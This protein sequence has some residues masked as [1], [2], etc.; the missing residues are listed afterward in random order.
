[1]S[2]NRFA[3]HVLVFP[4]DDANRQIAVG[5]RLDI[6]W[7]RR[8]AILPVAGGWNEVLDRFVTDHIPEME[9]NENRLMILLIDFDGQE[10]R[11][12][13]ASARI[14]AHLA[15]R[16]FILGV[17]TNPEHLRQTMHESFETIGTLL[18]QDCRDGTATTWNRDLLRH[19]ER[20][21]DRLR[22]LVHPI[23]Y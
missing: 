14:P 18:S 19:N 10:D 6:K 16:V 1:V 5:F 11:F 20:E 2:V 8:M 4:E 9:K 23:L 15:D 22:I 17:L 21:L 3:P 7:I 13:R 12:R